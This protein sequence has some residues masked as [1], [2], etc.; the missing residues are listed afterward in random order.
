ME[1]S[2]P[3]Q[4]S[5][6]IP[7]SRDLLEQ[8]WLDTHSLERF[9]TLWLT[10]SESSGLSWV[11]LVARGLALLSCP[12]CP[13]PPFLDADSWLK[14]NE[15]SK[16]SANSLGPVNLISNPSSSYQLCGSR[17]RYLPSPCLCFLK[18]GVQI[19]VSTPSAVVR[20]KGVTAL[21]RPRTV[22]G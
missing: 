13:P 22:P 20:G 19:T 21:E 1:F 5:L 10:W 4:G 8:D 17:E 2:A 3:L 7:L 14:G 16:G 11:L 15:E 18:L 12:W 9:F 6:A